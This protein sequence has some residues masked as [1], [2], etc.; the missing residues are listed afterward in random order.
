MTTA[1]R[2]ARILETFT[3]L[4]DTLVDA[5]DVVELLQTLV[6]TC[7]D[8]L[9]I[10][11]AGIL[12]A[13][14]DQELEVVAST[15]EATRLVEVLQLDAEAGPCMTSFATGRVVTCPDIE[16]APAEWAM[17]RTGAL[18]LGFRSVHA[19]PLRL[20]SN[21]IGTLNLFG[22]GVGSLAES[23]LRVARALADVATIG[24]LHER[25]LR[26]HEVVRA[27][28]QRTIGSREVI[29]QA[30]G[31]V[32]YLRGVSI[33]DAFAVIRG[34]ALEHHEPLSEVARA[35]VQRRLVP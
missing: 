13:N 24:I 23:D 35:I 19:V 18:A 5:Y 9:G 26:E 11:A 34:Y 6:E 30:K 33:E 29:E 2:E 12:L 10:D 20:G 8:V 25:S 4:A 32:S 21:V 31:V 7:A 15:S 28:L 17:F 27:Q 1:G 14:D 3:S 22:V 16:V